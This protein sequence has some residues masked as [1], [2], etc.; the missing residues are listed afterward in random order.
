[1]VDGEVRCNAGPIIRTCGHGKGIA[2]LGN[3][4]SRALLKQDRTA[5]NMQNPNALPKQYRCDQSYPGDAGWR[6]ARTGGRFLMIKRTILSEANESFLKCSTS[7]QSQKSLTPRARTIRSPRR[8]QHLLT[9]FRR[10]YV[11]RI[12]T[13]AVLSGDRA[14]A[15]PKGIFS[16]YSGL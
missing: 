16:R 2:G 7:W 4:S 12:Q 8:L 11:V 5:L 14:L 6:L 1:M 15:K 13:R 3:A 9:V 10:L